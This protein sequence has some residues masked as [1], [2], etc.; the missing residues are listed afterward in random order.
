ME[1]GRAWSA[2]QTSDTKARIPYPPFAFLVGSL[3][4]R[5]YVASGCVG[6][7]RRMPII[8]L[9][10]FSFSFSSFLLFFFFTSL[11]C[12]AAA[13]HFFSSGIVL[14]ILYCYCCCC[15]KQMAYL[16]LERWRGFGLVGLGYAGTGC[17]GMETGVCVCVLLRACVRVCGRVCG[18]VA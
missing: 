6:A 3:Y 2:V 15:V 10:R 5:T 4:V 12:C 17:M 16:H 8:P 1:G 13:L 14:W 18:W 11:C 9:V 7:R